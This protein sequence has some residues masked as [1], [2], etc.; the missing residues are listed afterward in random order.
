MKKVLYFLTGCA[1]FLAACDVDKETVENTEY[2]KLTY[3]DPK[4]SYIKILN[5][6]LHPEEVI[7]NATNNIY[8]FFISF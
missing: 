8:I 6:F 1:M 3:G 7:A 5:H 2:E 4:Y